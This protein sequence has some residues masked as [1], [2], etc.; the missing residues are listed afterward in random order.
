MQIK[1]YTG[2]SKRKNSTKQPTGGTTVTV[3]LKYP[4][5][6]VSPSFDVAVAHA[7]SNYVYVSDW[8]RYYFV[9][10]VTY[11]TNAIVTLK[12]ASDPM[13]SAKSNIGA[14]NAPVE[15]ATSSVNLL[16]TDPRNRPTFKYDVV[17]TKILDLTAQS[18]A[19][20]HSPGRY[21]CGI[22]CD[23]GIKYFVFTESGLDTL[24][25]GL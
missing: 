6:K 5:D 4:V 1:V 9:T 19:F 2:F 13:A 10:G 12:C 21:V 16:L 7:G 8:G 15:F 14:V 11:Q 22:V 18:P 20:A 3:A 24:C 17:T 25:E 23:Q